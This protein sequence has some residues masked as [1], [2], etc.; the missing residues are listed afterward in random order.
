MEHSEN[1]LYDSIMV[2]ICH[3]SFVQTHRM[4]S[5]KMSP[6]ANCGLGDNDM[7]MYVHQL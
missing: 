7:S 5:T 2:D 6:N 4:Y 1:T 3:Y